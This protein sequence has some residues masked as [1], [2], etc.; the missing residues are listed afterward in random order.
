[1]FRESITS[2]FD[3]V[4]EMV[5]SRNK[6]KLENRNTGGRFEIKTGKKKD[7]IVKTD[8]IRKRFVF[9]NNIIFKNY[10]DSKAFT[11]NLIA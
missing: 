6:K 11:S 10:Y 8:R 2:L 7:A 4:I 9:V 1:M 5:Q 3:M